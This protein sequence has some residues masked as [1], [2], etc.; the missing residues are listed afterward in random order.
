MQFKKAL[1]V[2]FIAYLLVAHEVEAFWGALAKV[3][4]SVLPSLFSKRSS[5]RNV[6]KREVGNFFDPYQKD[7][8][9]DDLFAQLD[10]Y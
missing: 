1:L 6:R 3:A 2:M 10:K 5:L 4:T 9:L 8:D 7:L